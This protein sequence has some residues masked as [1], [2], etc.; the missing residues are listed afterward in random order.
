MKGQHRV[1]AITALALGLCPVLRSAPDASASIGFENVFGRSGITF[2]LTVAGAHIAG[3]NHAGI[4][5]QR[6]RARLG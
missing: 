4:P 5:P 3:Q 1:A 6:F 2:R